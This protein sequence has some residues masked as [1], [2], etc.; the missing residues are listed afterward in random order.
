MPDVEL[1]DDALALYDR[2]IRLWGA[3]AQ[4]RLGNSR[5]CLLGIGPLGSEIA[6][7]LVLGGIG[8]IVVVDDEVVRHNEPTFFVDVK[9]QAGEVR[10]SA[11]QKRLQELNPRVKVQTVEKKW[12]ELETDFFRGFD[13]VL[14]T[15]LSSREIS[16]LN[17]IT[18]ELNI[19]LLAPSC[20][21][22]YGIV[23]L[24]GGVDCQSWITKEKNAQRQL[25][26]MDALGL[27]ELIRMEDIE[28]N[29]VKLDR[30]LVKSNYRKWDDQ[31]RLFISKM[32]PTERKLLKRLPKSFA[33]L[34]SLLEIDSDDE[35]TLE[36]LR[37]NSKSVLDKYQ[38]SPSKF[39]DDETLEKVLQNSRKNFQPVAAIIGGFISQTTINIIVQRDIPANNLVILDGFKNEMPIFTI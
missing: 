33:A 38:L 29:G 24:D 9:T 2:Q 22:L 20:H 23:F 30:C 32:F 13:L 8:E 12:L 18:R 28:E 35:V 19:P 15:N 14:G 37:I 21:G 26:P 16:K 11:S 5:I 17:S 39:I 27:R 10:S 3:A 34:L 7:N 6:K 31:S 36:N 4:A 25:G 1:A